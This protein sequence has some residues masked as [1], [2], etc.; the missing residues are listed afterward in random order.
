MQKAVTYNVSEKF[1][2]SINKV[3]TKNIITA[4]N[5]L[6]TR[7]VRNCMLSFSIKLTHTIISIH[8]KQENLLDM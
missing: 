1:T 3:T 2:A 7:L 8:I 5:H 6:Q 4:Y